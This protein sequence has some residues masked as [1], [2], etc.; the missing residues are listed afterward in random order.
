MAYCFILN[1]RH[2]EIA[3]SSDYGL[4][5]NIL[6]FTFNVIVKQMLS[7]TPEN[8]VAVRI[9]HEFSTFMKGLVSVPINIPGTPYAKAV[10]VILHFGKL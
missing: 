2:L 7:L 3:K 4:L 10:Q 8:P 1:A 5:H 9:L 6:Q